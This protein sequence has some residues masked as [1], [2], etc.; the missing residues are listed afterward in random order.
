VEP[1]LASR[2]PPGT[3]TRIHDV[4][5]RFEEAWYGA[6]SPPAIEPFLIAISSDRRNALLLDLVHTDLYQ[7]LRAHLPVQVEDYLQRYPEL[8]AQHEEIV[9]LIVAEWDARR[10]AGDTPSVAEYCARFPDDQPELMSRLLE[11]TDKGEPPGAPLA[12]PQ[13]PGFE[14]LEQLGQG[15]M[16][17]VYKARQ[18]APARVVALKMILA[19]AHAGPEDVGRFRTEADAVAGLQHPHVVQLFQV[20]DHNGLPYFCMELC[21]GG[22]LAHQLQAAPLEPRQAAALLERLAGA[23][24]AAHRQ[25]ILHRDLKPANVLLTAEGEPKISDFGLAKR[26]DHVSGPTQTG[27]IVGTPSY[28]APEQAQGNSKEIGPAADVYALGAILYECL[29]GRPPFKA[30]TT[31][32]TLRQVLVEEP[33]PPSRLQPGVP[34]DLETICL[35]CLEKDRARRYPSAADLAADLRRHQRDEP[36]Q[37]RRTGAWERLRKFARRN[38]GLTAGLAAG[39]FALLV[40]IAALVAIAVLVSVHNAELAQTNQDL[41]QTREFAQQTIE[42]MTSEKA[43]Q[44]LEV[45]RELRPEQQAFLRQAVAYHERFAAAAAADAPGRQRQAHASFRVGSLQARLGEEGPAEAAFRASLARWQQLAADFPDEPRYRYRLAVTHNALGSLHSSQG[46]WAEAENALREALAVHEQLPAEFR[47]TPEGTESLAGIHNSL[48]ALCGELGDREPAVAYYR[49][50]VAEYEQLARA[51]P[52]TPGYR[53]ILAGCLNN[54]GG[55]LCRMGPKEKEEA[56]AVQ[57]KALQIAEQ[58]VGEFPTEFVYEGQLG[59]IHHG[60]GI[61]RVNLGQE[62]EAATHFEKAI[63]ILVPVTKFFPGV[64]SYQRALASTYGQLGDLTVHRRVRQLP[65]TPE[66]QAAAEAAY[67][68]SLLFWEKLAAHSHPGDEV[69]FELATVYVG[70][71]SLVQYE[72]QKPV[73]AL[74][75][76]TKGIEALEP[77]RQRAPRRP[78]VRLALRDAFWGQANALMTQGSYGEAI[79]TWDGAIAMDDGWLAPQFGVFRAGCLACQEEHDKATREAERIARIPGLSN[80]MYYNCAGVFAMASQPSSEYQNKAKEP[81][82]QQREHYARRAVE[83]LEQARLLGLFQEEA[84]VKQ[85]KEE[86]ALAHL[87]QR[88]DFQKLLADVGGQR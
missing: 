77:V 83:L 19:G 33:V 54:L 58:L 7:R 10:H 52:E 48:G 69:Q 61:T 35:K 78:R 85:M 21:G 63:A 87:R 20:G 70:F 6:E 32:E 15:G 1:F 40:G 62:A 23:V 43:L 42:D 80:V 57:E 53:S 34:R 71:A 56:K 44:F 17:K 22:S 12:L 16:G 26:L 50:A 9:D 5:T 49:Q 39:L 86:P 46:H 18:L 81:S 27:A 8:R 25:R 84:V 66:Q 59:L 68:R 13:V 72:G 37:A 36:V 82:E 24:E 74:P 60:L 31:L 38:R 64:P 3:Q 76:Y 11:Q 67:G 55:V 51:L 4:V 45:Q 29:T 14:L 88:K 75:W 47:T 30:A 2:R 73:E 65:N 41:R 79:A 28:M